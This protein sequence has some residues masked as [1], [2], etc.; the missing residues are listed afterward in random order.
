MKKLIF[1]FFLSFIVISSFAQIAKDLMFGGGFDLIKTDNNGAFSKAQI[2]IEANYFI[3]KQFTGTAGVDI[4]TD[5]KTS[6]VLGG[7]WYPMDDFFV[8]ARGFIG[9]N[10]LAI[11]A[12][13]SKPFKENWK[14]EA[15]G[16][17]YFHLDFAVRVGVAYVIRRNK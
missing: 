10:D 6:F 13:W 2:G 16:D 11:G 9:A 12:G 14:F 15:M 4:W 7:R 1:T 5:S 17:F 8:R 3:D